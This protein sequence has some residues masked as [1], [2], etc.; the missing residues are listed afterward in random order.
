MI[1][2]LFHSPRAILPKLN[3]YKIFFLFLF[4][5]SLEAEE[6]FDHY[7]PH[8]ER[9]IQY[10]YPTER[11][12]DAHSWES[13]YSGLKSLGVSMVHRNLFDRIWHREEPGFLGYHGST[14]EYRIYQDIIR[15]IIEEHI[16]IPIREDFHFFR[17]P[18]DPQ[19]HH[20]NLQEYGDYQ[21]NYSPTHF[22]CMNYALYGNFQS[23]ASCS[24]YYFAENS[25]LTHI[26]YERKLEWLFNK[27]GI[28]SSMIYEAF[29]IGRLYLEAEKG[30]LIQVFDM[31]HFNPWRKHYDLSDGQCGG[32]AS[33]P[34][35]EIVAG[36]HPTSFP[37]QIRML[38]SNRHTLNPYSP[39]IIKRYDALDPKVIQEY[40]QELREF[41]A[42]LIPEEE[43]MEQYKKE[44]L[45]VWE[46]TDDQ[47]D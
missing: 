46:V 37:W 2:S 21:W 38:M 17:I 27:L 30:I 11:F 14:Q 15:L 26:N 40:E 5:C 41:I 28:D 45:E 44:L 23:P 43:K 33:S 29:T 35:S 9:K 13:I 7:P 4:F 31:S 12:I 47:I 3:F 6:I 10:R 20:Q 19:F 32:F 16:K 42:K 25:S 1:D 34:I 39:L 22:L 18:G 24:Y 36:T 8:I